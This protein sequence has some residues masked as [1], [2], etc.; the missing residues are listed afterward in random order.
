MIYLLISFR[1]LILNLFF[2][3]FIILSNF[4]TFY[5]FLLCLGKGGEKKKVL[6]LLSGANDVVKSKCYEFLLQTALLLLPDSYM[7]E[8]DRSSSSSNAYYS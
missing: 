7:K 4:S 8:A 2:S 3:L 6:L 1:H 5:F